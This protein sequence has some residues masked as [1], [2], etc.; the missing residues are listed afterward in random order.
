MAFYDHRFVFAIA[1]TAACSP[2]FEA[3][4]SAGAGSMNDGGA[5]AAAHPTNGG[6]GGSKASGGSSGTKGASGSATDGGS[7]AQAGTGTSGK[8]MDGGSPSGGDD[9]GGTGATTSSGGADSSGGIDAKGGTA[10]LG[11]GGASPLA[12]MGGTLVVAGMGG[13]APSAGMGGMLAVSGMAGA[14]PTAGAP[15]AGSGNVLGG[16]DNQLLANGDFEA[17][18]T[19]S[20]GEESTWPGIEIIVA[21]TNSALVAENVTPY[22]GTYLAWL[23]GIPDNDWDHNLV[24]LTQDVTLPSDAATLTLSGYRWVESVDDDSGAFDVAFLEFDDEAGDVVWQAQAW[25]NQ[26]TTNGWSAFQAT[27]TVEPAY[28]GQKLTL[29]AYSNT[30]P[31]GKTSFFLDNLVLI[32][33]CG[34]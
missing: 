5:G 14:L 19:S 27:T 22:A 8:A 30:D 3:A 4:S 12:G 9:D 33:S 11:T 20:W 15:S 29:V 31:G 17:G 26:T 24:T 23:G 6:V 1:L 28:R 21:S 2:D 7:S 16:C 13:T 32:A 34:R 10:G 25:S 18:P